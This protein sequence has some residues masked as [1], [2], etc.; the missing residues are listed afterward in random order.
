ML[1]L[2]G[3]PVWNALHFLVRQQLA[4]HQMK[5]ELEKRSLQTITLN[6]DEIS[7]VRKNKE[8]VIQ[9]RLFDVKQLQIKGSHIELTGLFD[10]AEE[11]IQQAFEKSTEDEPDASSIVHDWVWED[12]INKDI[13]FTTYLLQYN[14]IYS[15]SL[16]LRNAVVFSPPPEV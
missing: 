14:I 1:F 6:K 2:A 11:A 9:G 3:M 10:D 13:V 16:V 7:W 4:R 12:D 15:A 5:E 8:A